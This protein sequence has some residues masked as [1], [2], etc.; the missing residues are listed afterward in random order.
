MVKRFITVLAVGGALAGAS[1]AIPALAQTNG[2]HP[3]TP[4]AESGTESTAPENSAADPDNV[5]YT[6]PGDPDYK[7]S[8]ATPAR[9]SKTTVQR[10]HSTSRRTTVTHPTRSTS[11]PGTAQAPTAQAPAEQTPADET[12]SESESST[13][14]E[15][16]VETEAGQPGEPVNGHEDAAGQNAQHECTGDCVE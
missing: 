1:V 10:R 7:G 6:A 12:S 16:S 4:A 11:T 15:S 13:E 14:S 8:T 5:Q 2:S 3:S 9:T